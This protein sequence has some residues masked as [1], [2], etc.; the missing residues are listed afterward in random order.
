MLLALEESICLHVFWARMLH[1]ILMHFIIKYRFFQ[2]VEAFSYD[3]A[4]EV[5]DFLIG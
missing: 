4:S 1:P 5:K 2:V 3:L